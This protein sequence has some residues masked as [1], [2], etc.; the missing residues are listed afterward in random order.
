V[1]RT[2]RKY[3]PYEARRRDGWSDDAFE[4]VEHRD[5]ARKRRRREREHDALED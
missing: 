4:G 3:N 1:S 2:F 5:T